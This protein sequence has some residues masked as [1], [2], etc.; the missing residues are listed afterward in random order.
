M[1]RKVTAALTL[2]VVFGF[3]AA[4]RADEAAVKKP[5]GTWER[6]VGDSEVQ[7]LFKADG[8]RVVIKGG[9]ATIDVEADYGL[10][11]GG[12][13]YGIVSKTKT[14]GTNDGPSEG[15]LFSFRIAV[16]KDTLTISEL[17]G[18]D[19]DEARKLIEGEYKKVAGK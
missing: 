5:V 6:K 19:N 9:G 18:T 2:A 7:F 11:K 12:T 3:V 16:D 17:K 10:T 1:A 14:E 15:H 13:V 8:L 4:A